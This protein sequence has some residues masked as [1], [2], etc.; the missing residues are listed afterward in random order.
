MFSG[1][2]PWA[3]AFLSKGAKEGT[4]GG[5]ILNQP[6][7]QVELLTLRLPKSGNHLTFTMV[8]KR[9]WSWGGRCF[10]QTPKTKET[11]SAGVFQSSGRV[12]S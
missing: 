5:S 3:Q 7:M 10:G 9:G 4:E 6:G 2:S 8:E 12:K 1:S 11:I